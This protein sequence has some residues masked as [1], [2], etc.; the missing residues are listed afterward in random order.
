MSFD[1]VGL[2]ATRRG[3]ALKDVIEFESNSRCTFAAR[4]GKQPALAFVPYEAKDYS[5]NAADKGPEHESTEKLRNVHG[6]LLYIAKRVQIGYRESCVT[7][8]RS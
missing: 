2:I 4:I 5:A 6:T 7:I 8:M 3:S 1:S